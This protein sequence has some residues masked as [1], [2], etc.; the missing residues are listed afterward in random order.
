MMD[1]NKRKIVC[2]DE[3]SM[4]TFQYGLYHN[5]KISSSPRANC[6]HLRFVETIHMWLGVSHFGCTPCVVKL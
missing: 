4:Q 6:V 5:R 2:V 1:K 3:S